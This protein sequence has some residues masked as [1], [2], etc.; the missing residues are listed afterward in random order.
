MNTMSFLPLIC[1]YPKTTQWNSISSPTDQKIQALRVQLSQ[2]IA[3]QKLEDFTLECLDQPPSTTE[4]HLAISK[5]TVR[6]QANTKLEEIDLTLV[7][8]DGNSI[9]LLQPTSDQ[10]SYN[11]SGEDGKSARIRTQALEFLSRTVFE[12]V[13]GQLLITRSTHAQIPQTFDLANQAL[14]KSH[15]SICS[16]GITFVPK[17]GLTSQHYSGYSTYQNRDDCFCGRD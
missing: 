12:K 10:N 1:I 14:A 13:D 16:T 3:Q 2:A 4:D 15:Y 7:N 8:N 9:F 11:H 17:S 6:S 5:F